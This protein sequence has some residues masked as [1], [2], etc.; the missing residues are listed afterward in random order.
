M[1]SR[2]ET[3]K[4]ATH[5][6]PSPHVDTHNVFVHN[7]NPPCSVMLT[8]VAT[9]KC[10][11]TQEQ[12]GLV[13]MEEERRGVLPRVYLTPGQ[14]EIK[15]PNSTVMFVLITAL[16]CSNEVATGVQQATSSHT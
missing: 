6:S 4:N 13:S 15:P 9:L 3:G 5:G 10:Q 7:L 2:G 8:E 14:I 1:I 12:P 11:H 16:L